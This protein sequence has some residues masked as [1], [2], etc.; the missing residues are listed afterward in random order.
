MKLNQLRQLIRE[1]IEN[2]TQ[3]VYEPIDEMGKFYIVEKPKRG[4]K[5]EDIMRE[6]TAF[7]EIVKENTIG[8]YKQRSDA[9]RAA[10]EAI[11][12]YE[13]QLQEL[14]G[15]MEE[16]RKHKSELEEKKKKAK[17]TITRL[18]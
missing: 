10:T 18:K 6:A 15:Q 5:K 12:E 11:K 8:I 16:F 17:E 4:S 14:E 9:N 3:E 1:E 13:T 2:V 7:D